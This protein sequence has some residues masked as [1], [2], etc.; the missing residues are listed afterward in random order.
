MNPEEIMAWI[1]SEEGYKGNY[2]E[3]MN[4][5]GMRCYAT[6]PVKV[7]YYEDQNNILVTEGETL[8]DALLRAIEIKIEVFAWEP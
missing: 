7:V 6:T 3:F 2:L 5:Y 1:N 8:L 4:D